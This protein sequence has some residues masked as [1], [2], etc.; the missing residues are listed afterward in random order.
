M[1]EG[2][3]QLVLTTLVNIE[4]EELSGETTNP[5]NLSGLTFQRHLGALLSA[6]SQASNSAAS[7]IYP[8]PPSFTL[9]PAIYPLIGFNSLLESGSSPLGNALCSLPEPFL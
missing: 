6:L 8:S 7:P 3:Q 1:E 2:G 9:S 4:T 5:S